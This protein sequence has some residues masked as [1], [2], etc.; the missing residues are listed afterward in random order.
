MLIGPA[1][2]FITGSDILMDGE[3]TAT[4]IY[5]D[6]PEARTQYPAARLQRRTARRPSDLLG[7]RPETNS[8]AGDHNPAVV[9]LQDR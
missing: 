8:S 9:R 4:Y 6:I 5:G 7:P 1:D 2:G 3:V